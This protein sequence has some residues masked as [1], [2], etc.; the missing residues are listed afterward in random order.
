MLRR[1]FSRER[2]RASAPTCWSAASR[3]PSPGRREL[4]APALESLV[5][6]YSNVLPHE[7]VRDRSAISLPYRSLV[8]SSPLPVASKSARTHLTVAVCGKCP[9]CIDK[10][11]SAVLQR[12]SKICCIA[13]AACF[14]DG[15][16]CV[17][18]DVGVCLRGFGGCVCR[19][20]AI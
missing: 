13:K 6:F 10:P 9:C 5:F 12:V 3:H 15:D 14:G 19:R 16:A 2:V 4:L 7:N 17:V 8:R 20:A 18:S 1:R 11:K